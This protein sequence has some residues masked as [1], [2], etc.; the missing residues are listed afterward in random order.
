M[1]AF[2]SLARQTNAV[3]IPADTGD[4]SGMVARALAVFTSVNETLSAK[5]TKT[6]E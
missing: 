2:K 4:A 3:I 6:I 5:S 1:D